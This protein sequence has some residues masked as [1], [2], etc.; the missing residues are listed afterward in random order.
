MISPREVEGCLHAN[1]QLQ[2]GKQSQNV[3]TL[4][5]EIMLLP[6]FMLMLLASSLVIGFDETPSNF[7]P[8]FLRL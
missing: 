2:T 7:L 6:R 1:P 5:L 4:A 8:S 3:C